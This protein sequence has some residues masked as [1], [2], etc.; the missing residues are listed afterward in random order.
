MSKSI[1]KFLGAGTASTSRTNAENEILNYLKK[2]DTSNYD[3]T[4]SNLNS[5]AANASQ[6]LGNMGNYNQMMKMNARNMEMN[7]GNNMNN[8]ANNRM[9]NNMN[10]NQN[11]MSV[12]DI[13]F[14]SIEI[15]AQGW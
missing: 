8:M 9:G 6:N 2:Y 3:T 1:G 7:Y 4:L 15:E 10:K 14:Y 13:L 5:F 12:L 11:K